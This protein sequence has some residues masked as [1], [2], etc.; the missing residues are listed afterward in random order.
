V[1]YATTGGVTDRRPTAVERRPTAADRRPTA[2]ERRRTAAVRLADH[3]T[4]ERVSPAPGIAVYFLGVIVESLGLGLIA[5]AG[6]WV[7]GGAIFICG[8]AIGTLGNRL[9]PAGPAESVSSLEA[10]LEERRGRGRV[11]VG[12]ARLESRGVNEHGSVAVLT[13]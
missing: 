6:W 2:A 9:W 11:R 5:A 1:T 3:V 4:R 7:L 13:A 10:P 8:L 12:K